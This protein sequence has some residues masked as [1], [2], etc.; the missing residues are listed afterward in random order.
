MGIELGRQIASEREREGMSPTDLASRLDTDL[1]EVLA[2]ESGTLEPDEAKLG[3]IQAAL[4]G[5]PVDENQLIAGVERTLTA[6]R[7]QYGPLI[8]SILGQW[9]QTVQNYRAGGPNISE[10]DLHIL[11]Y[12]SRHEPDYRE[13]EFPKAPIDAMARLIRIP[14]IQSRIGAEAAPATDA[15]SPVEAESSADADYATIIN[16]RFADVAAVVA[17]LGLEAGLAADA[18]AKVEELREGL[19]RLEQPGAALDEDELHWLANVLGEI[20]AYSEQAFS[21]VWDILAHPTIARVI[22]EAVLE[23]I[24]SRVS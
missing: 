17:G 21:K 2:I 24:L 10:D 16:S 11:E 1:L 23:F 8:N 6:E 5:L 22:G 20:K 19:L 12:F 4:P 18:Q 9:S 7:S 3:A 13:A 15:G 14:A